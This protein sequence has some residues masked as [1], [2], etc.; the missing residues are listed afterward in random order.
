MVDF[1]AFTKVYFEYQIEADGYS[2]LVIYGR[3]INGGFIAIPNHNVSVEASTNE[4]SRDYN[5]G[6][7]ISVGLSEQTA[8]QIA[9]IIERYNNEHRQQIEDDAK[10]NRDRLFK[11]K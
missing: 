2:Y 10:R 1:T 4:N 6:K 11:G 7:L 9:D 5:A 8:G 3:H